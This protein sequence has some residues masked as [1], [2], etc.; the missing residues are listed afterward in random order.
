MELALLRHRGPGLVPEL[1]RIHALRE[2]DVL[3]GRVL[4]TRSAGSGKDKDSRW[5]DIYEGELDVEQM[6]VWIRQA[7]DM[8]G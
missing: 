3:A 5:T 7:A 2:G 8:P 6:A 4:E 1:P